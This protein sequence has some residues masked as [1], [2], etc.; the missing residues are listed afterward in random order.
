MSIHSLAEQFVEMC[1]QGK[2]FDVMNAMY[3]PD[4]VSIEADGQE[5]SGKSAVIQK[6]EHWGED[7]TVTSEKVD[8]PF[9]NGPSKFAV[10][11]TFEVIPK[12]T[13]TPIKLEEVAVYTVDEDDQITREQF[14]YDGGR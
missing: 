9:Y 6:S 5:T 14:F 1:N 8:G 4:I 3:A 11:Y 13:G 7:N 2:N 12:S 10:H